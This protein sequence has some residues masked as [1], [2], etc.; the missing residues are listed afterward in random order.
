MKNFKTKVVNQG[1][2]S[3][4]WWEIQV[5]GLEACEDCEYL[6]TEECGG[7]KIRK[8]LKNEKGMKIPLGKE[9]KK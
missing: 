4:E 5:W 1:E 2:M 8:N 9:L 7:K 6:N 3:S